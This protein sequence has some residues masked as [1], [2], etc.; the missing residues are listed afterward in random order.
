MMELLMSY[1]AVSTGKKSLLK[2]EWYFSVQL[3]AIES[4]QLWWGLS[5]F[6]VEIFSDDEPKAS[7]FEKIET[8]KEESP[9]HSNQE[10]KIWNDT[11]WI[12][13]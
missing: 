1:C 2:Q 3:V 11:S 12:G 10:L 13:K 4:F 9:I 5:T 6:H 7:Q 8:W